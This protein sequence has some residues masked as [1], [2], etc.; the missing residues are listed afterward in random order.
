MF[1]LLTFIFVLLS[2]ETCDLGNRGEVICT[3]MFAAV[4]VKVEGKQL[5]DFYTIRSSTGETI[6]HEM[7]FGDSVYTVLDDN[8][9]SELKNDQDTFMFYGYY[10]G[11][12][13]VEEEYI[14]RADECH[15][16]KV[17]GK[18]RVDI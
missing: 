18:S 9:V 10:R 16:D 17:S 13:V 11:E 4:T 15:V 8:Y 2:V 1:R 6:R 7:M 3:E 5:N 14:I 12:L